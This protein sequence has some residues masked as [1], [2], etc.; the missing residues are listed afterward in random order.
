MFELA[1]KRIR[2]AALTTLMAA[3][4]ALSASAG[5]STPARGAET[6]PTAALSATDV[7]ARSLLALLIGIDSTHAFGSTRAAQM[8]ADE[9]RREGFADT[10]VELLLPQSDKGNVLIHLHGRGSR[11]PILFI[12]HLDVVEARPEDW[13]VPPFT[14]TERDGYFYGR[15]TQDMKDDIAAAVANLIR[16]HAEHYRPDRDLYFAFTSDEEAGGT[17]NGVKWLLDNR[18][19]LRQVDYVVNFDAGGGDSEHGRPELM[20]L[21]T[22]EKESV[23]FEL[24]VTNAGG[25]S[26]LPT[27][28]NA[29]FRLAAGLSRL[30]SLEF[31]LH[32]TATTRGY[33]QGASSTQAPALRADMLAVARTGDP[34]AAARLSMSAA[35]YNATLRTTCTA[36]QLAAGH[37]QNALPQ[38]ALATI[39][40]RLI[41]GESAESTRDTLVK[42]LADPQIVVRLKNQ[43]IPSPETAVDPQLFSTLQAV[44]AQLWPSVAVVPAMDAGA[45]D[46][47]FPRNLGIPAFGISGIFNDIDD[48]RAHGRDERVRVRSFFADVEFQ[49]RLFR[50]L[51]G[52]R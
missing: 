10:D 43:P 36:T 26:S 50:A 48:N 51:G 22:S 28:D 44:T 1:G 2:T 52:G 40:C 6:S 32:P 13:S 30:A 31:P 12:G 39:Q 46:N 42:S 33:L 35:M 15:G 25:H 4:A 23:T 21:Q 5:S 45:S 27:P 11:K 17:L 9:L 49:Y 24:E 34:A 16:L 38:R 3:F 41:P 8:I 20:R 29:I 7:K 18:L 14:L 47:I 37:A 19:E